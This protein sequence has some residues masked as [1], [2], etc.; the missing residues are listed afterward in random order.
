MSHEYEGKSWASFTFA[1]E[2]T[3]AMH[4]PLDVLLHYYFHVWQHGFSLSIV[5]EN[6]M[7]WTFLMEPHQLILTN[8][9]I[10]EYY[11]MMLIGIITWCWS[12]LLHDADR[13]YCMMLIGIITW[14]W[15]AILRITPLLEEKF[16]TTSGRTWGMV[17]KPWLI[18]SPWCTVSTTQ[19]DLW[20]SYSVLDN[21]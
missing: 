13:H 3:I 2:T 6:G 17:I 8:M 16:Y 11:Y 21:Y 18:K 20:K 4:L 19:S 7:R 10:K 9:Y 12:A 15:S 14:C 1:Q 5:Y